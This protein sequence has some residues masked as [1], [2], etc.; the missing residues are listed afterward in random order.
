[1]LTQII[2]LKYEHALR[3]PAACVLRIYKELN[4]I[5]QKKCVL[6]VKQNILIK[7]IHQED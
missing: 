1:M 4:I 3:L 6:E 5:S 7:V 2:S